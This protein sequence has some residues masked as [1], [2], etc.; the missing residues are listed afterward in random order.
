MCNHFKKGHS[1]FDLLLDIPWDAR[2]STHSQVSGFRG[3]F[4]LSQIRLWNPLQTQEHVL[5]S[6]SCK[7]ISIQKYL[8]FISLVQYT[9]INISAEGICINEPHSSNSNYSKVSLKWT[10]LGSS[11]GVKRGLPDYKEPMKITEER[12][13]QSLMTSYLDR[14]LSDPP[15]LVLIKWNWVPYRFCVVAIP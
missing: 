14:R 15:P 10:P 9:Y 8:Q 5:R 12:Q 3:T 11:F 7:R 4:L 2:L 6:N 13:K 1:W